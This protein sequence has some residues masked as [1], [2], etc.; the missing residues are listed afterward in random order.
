MARAYPQSLPADRG[1]DNNDWQSLRGELVALLDQVE[2]QVARG[3]PQQDYDAGERMRDLRMQMEAPA[4]PA[5]RHREALRS[6]QRAVDRFSDRDEP[7]PANPRDTLQSAIDQIRSRPAAPGVRMDAGRLDEFAGAMGGMTARLE[8]IEGELKSGLRNGGDVKAI[9]DQVAQLAHVVELLAGAVGETG[10]VKRLEGQI[11]SLGR[12]VAQS[13]EA[14]MSGLTRR[15]DDMSTAMGRLA[16]L[17]VQFANKVENPVQSTAFKDG[18]QAIEASV[19]NVYDRID[20]LE[21]GGGVSP[22]T[23]EHLTTEMARFTD[24]MKTSAAPH[25]LIEL[26]DALNTRIADVESGD[27]LLHTLRKDLSGLRD[28]VTVSLEPRFDALERRIAAIAPGAQ[29]FS[30]ISQQLAELNSRIAERPIDSGVGQIEAQVRQLVARMDQT[31]EQLSGLAK[32]YTGGEPQMPDFEALADM[33]AARSGTGLSQAALDSLEL[34]IANMLRE[35]GTS[36]SG[37]E[38]SGMRQGIEEVNAR[39]QRLEAS[40]LERRDAEAE[41]QQLVAQPNIEW[42]MEAEPQSLADLP[43]TTPYDLPKRMHRPDDAMPASPAAEAP[44]TPTAYADPVVGNDSAKGTPRRHH[45]GLDDE[46]SL[47]ARYQSPPPPQPSLFEVGEKPPAPTPAPAPNLGPFTPE[48]PHSDVM[49]DS[50]PVSASS[51]NTFIEAARRAAQKS[52]HLQPSKPAP[53]SNS[54]IGRALARFQTANAGDEAAPTRRL[55]G[56]KPART[57]WTPDPVPVP[58]A[59]P[60]LASDIHPE[61]AA[62]AASGPDEQVSFLTRHRRVILLGAVLVAFGFLALNLMMKVASERAASAAVGDDGLT[63]GSIEGVYEAVP[64]QDMPVDISGP[65]VIEM[66]DSLKTG[67][68]DAAAAQG[69]TAVPSQDMPPAFAAASGGSADT[70]PVAPLVESLDSPVTVEMPPEGI[71]PVE[72]RQ[73]AANGDGRAQFEVA[74][75]YTEGRAVPQDFAQA[76]IW[77]ERAAA[78]GFAP[79]QYRLGSLYESGEGLEKDLVTAKLWYERAAEKGNRMSM[80]NLAALYAGGALGKQQFDSAAKWFEEAASRGLTDSQ[81]NLGMLYARGLG[82]PQSLENSFKWFGIAALS[83]DNDAA[84]AR[85]DIARSLDAEAV[86]RLTAEVEAFKPLPIDL[87]ANFAPIGTWAKSFDPGEIIAQREIVASV[88]L[89]LGRLGYDVGV[90]DGVSGPKTAEA[91]KAFERATGM[92]EV[93]QINPRLLAVLGSQPV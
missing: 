14:D 13:R 79:A 20:T 75:I 92:T 64:M 76:A 66:V 2:S 39:L 32:L 17:Q 51:R 70:T 52:Q 6:V 3:R 68:I 21:R 42:P 15:L 85:D 12:I 26:I 8:R 59:E 55:A 57:E 16:D 74:A 22:A 90:P 27:R 45:P 31:G 28:A 89:A 47:A 82:V 43:P 54:L 18:M 62:N 10:Q 37:E 46:L 19:R 93:G 88:Q 78:Q 72:L 40:L 69:F 61:D 67:S 49:P 25:N 86:G 65:R 63:T 80:H 58:V 5:G 73:A 60:V 91:I 87:P 33:I 81:F 23:L 36:P 71:G 41:P 56:D 35:A 9:A 29:D 7:L 53:N 30:E 83:G 48:A 11:A 38:F 34:R 24:A 77:Y 44:L 1:S 4:E 50:A 84:K